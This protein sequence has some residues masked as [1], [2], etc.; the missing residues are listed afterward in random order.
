MTSCSWHGVTTAMM[1]N[2]GVT[3]APAVADDRSYLAEMMQSVE[4]IPSD[5][6]LGGLPWDWETHPQYL[7][8][9]QRM[10]AR[11]QRRVARRATAR[12]GTR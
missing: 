6:I 5:A 4:D 12:S 8:S 10:A 7:D 3:F 2:C 11:A 9:V 1:G